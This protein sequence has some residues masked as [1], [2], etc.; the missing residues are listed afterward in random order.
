MPMSAGRATGGA[1]FLT[2]DD[3]ARYQRDGFIVCPAI[4][5]APTMEVVRAELDR[6][7]AHDGHAGPTAH[8]HIDSRPVFDLVAQPAIV[9]RLAML[10]GPDLL[11]WHTRFFDKPP[12]DGEVPWHQDMAFW[13]I[14]PDICASVW[15]A[16]DHADVGNGCVHVIPGSH[17]IR[18]PHVSSTDTGRFGQRAAPGAIDESRKV[19]IEVKPGEFIIFDRWLIHG[20]PPNRSDRRRLALSAR[21]VPASVKVAFERMRPTF[22]ELGA[23]VIRGIDSAGLNR[24]VAPP[25]PAQGRPGRPSEVSVRRCGEERSGSA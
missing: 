23:Q 19:P 12:G 7:L 10:L 18:V 21:I 8:R 20:S 2:A 3:Q 25:K 17:R 13:P 1:A 24:I 9:D 4:H 16:I 22:P 11:L 6:V 5:D 15:I 14:E